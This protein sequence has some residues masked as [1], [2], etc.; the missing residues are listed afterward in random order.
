MIDHLVL[1]EIQETTE[2]QDIQMMTEVQDIQM[3]TEVQDIPEIMIENKQ[4]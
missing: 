3:M 4:L 1:I 2:V